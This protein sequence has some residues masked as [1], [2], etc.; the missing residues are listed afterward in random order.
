MYVS[1]SR[2]S[3]V[4]YSRICIHISR[5]LHA[6]SLRAAFMIDNLL[7]PLDA[8][9][10]KANCDIYVRHIQINLSGAKPRSARQKLVYIRNC[11]C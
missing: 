2:I 11:S 4:E 8:C 10:L 5:I 3:D 1:E 7:P 9:P 6:L